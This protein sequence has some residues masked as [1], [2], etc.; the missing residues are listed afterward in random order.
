MRNA[1]VLIAALVLAGC[2]QDPLQRELDGM[3]GK[4]VQELAAKL[5]RPT[6]GERT[7]NGPTYHWIGRNVPGAD[8][9]G[10]MAA[11][12]CSIKVKTDRQNVIYD[13]SSSGNSA[14]CAEFAAALRR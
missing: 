9:T 11:R 6:D 8:S 5:G 1:P 4:N 14:V 10:P 2:A 3:V 7:V 12:R 13:T